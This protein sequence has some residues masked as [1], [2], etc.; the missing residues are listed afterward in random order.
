MSG[1]G[2]ADNPSPLADA[3]LAARLL[4]VAPAALGG[5]SLR[6]GGPAR[7]CVIDAL[8]S[9]FP[10]RRIPPHIDEERLLGGVDIVASLTAGKPVMQ[11]GLLADAGGTLLIAPMAERM[12]DGLAG[13]LAQAMDAKA[14]FC[15][16][17]LDD[18]R[19]ADE[20]APGTLLDRIAFH[21]E[22]SKVTKLQTDHGEQRRPIALG[23]VV[24]ASDEALKTLAG[25]AMALGV[26]S[27]RPL[28]F[29]LNAARAHAAL[30]GREGI[31]QDDLTAAARLVLAPRATRI[32]Q[33]PEEQT[34]DEPPPPPP[35]HSET[36][37][38]SEEQQTGE[39]IPDDLV[40]EAALAAIPPD[41]LE[42]IAKDDTRRGASG[43]GSGNRT[44]SKL[45]GKPLGARPGQPRDGA[46]LALIDTLR[47]AV[48][49]QPLRQRESGSDT[50]QIR[51]TDLRIRRFEERAAS[52]T[53]FCVDASG[54]AA[55]ARLAEAKGAVELILAQA[56]V[57]RSE[58]ALIAFRGKGADLLLP[59]TRSLTRARRALAGLPGGGGTPLASGL[60]LAREL[61]TSIASRG[62]TPFLVFL[63]DGSAN[64]AA[65]GTPGRKQAREDAQTAAKA[66]A[67]SGLASLVIDIAPRPRDDAAKL[68]ADMRGRYLPLPFAD[69]QALSKVVLAAQPEKQTA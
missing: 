57:K 19:E 59:P 45:R 11:K 35:D 23:S 12:R 65:D 4:K 38:E 49:W 9:G 68:A 26:D 32:P 47:S 55:A 64:I 69:A 61:G 28:L 66:V 46:R 51:K 29:A 62:N 53:V 40:I 39:Q 24:P 8:K 56:Y 14:G 16:I 6:G 42:M 5:M 25:V 17:L 33:S 27:A 21:C 43:S 13:R 30:S 58:V 50:L 52:V 36:P 2:P 67:S 20:R 10:T 44:K 54:S 63:T 34:A 60:A 3:L 41:V 18:G 15:L 37:S 1:Q 7:D 31:A 22:L 48:P